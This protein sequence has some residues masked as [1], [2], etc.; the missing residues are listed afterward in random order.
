MTPSS[1]DPNMIG[2]SIDIVSQT[3]EKI[4][5]YRKL[6]SHKATYL[7]LLYLEVLFNMEILNTIEFKNLKD[8]LP[9]DI[10]VKVVIDLLETSIAEGIFYKNED[11]ADVDI[12]KSLEKKGKLDNVHKQLYI[13]EKGIEKQVQNN[14]IYINVLQAISFIVMKIKILQRLSELKDEELSE[15]VKSLKLDIRLININQRLLMIKQTMD[16]FDEVKSMSR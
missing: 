4:E 13:L 11:S 7:R 2:K 3:I 8:V 15:V 6:K 5:Q 12:Y 9:N 14:H 1:F 10:K 16:K